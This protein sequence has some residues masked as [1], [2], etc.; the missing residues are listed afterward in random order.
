VRRIR[1][2]LPLSDRGELSAS[3]FRVNQE[4]ERI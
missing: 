1:E 2:A 4:A 3:Q